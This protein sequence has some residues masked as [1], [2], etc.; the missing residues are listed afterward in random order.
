MSANDN[1]PKGFY[2]SYL[3]KLHR[4]REQAGL[5]PATDT[6]DESYWRERAK[7]HAEATKPLKKAA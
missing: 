2:I 3:E 5:P 7:W 1:R 6:D 4:Q